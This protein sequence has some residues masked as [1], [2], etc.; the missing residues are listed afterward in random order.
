MGIIRTQSIKNSL[1]LYLGVVVGAV[2]TI[3]I[4]PF[5]FEEHPEYWGL[6]QILVSYSIIFS[7]FSHLGSPNIIIRFFSKN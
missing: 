1:T 7:S 4:F 5:V 2:N 6:I 3:L